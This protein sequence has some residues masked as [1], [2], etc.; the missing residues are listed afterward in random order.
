MQGRRFEQAFGLEVRQDSRR[1]PRAF[2][3]AAVPHLDGESQSFGAGQFVL[4]RECAQGDARDRDVGLRPIGGRY[5][6]VLGIDAL[7]DR[8]TRGR[9]LGAGT[10]L[11]RCLTE[12]RFGGFQPGQGRD[13]PGAI[14]LGGRGTLERILGPFVQIH[15][16]E[17]VLQI[18]D[19]RGVGCGGSDGT[20]EI[21]TVAAAGGSVVLGGQFGLG[22][23]RPVRA[24]VPRCTAR[25]GPRLG[26][27]LARRDAGAAFSD[28]VGGHGAL[29]GQGL[30]GNRVGQVLSKA[31]EARDELLERLPTAPFTIGLNVLRELGALVSDPLQLVAQRI[32]LGTAPL[33]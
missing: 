12:L 31:V 1:S 18:E 11:A 26:D 5:A 29:H 21:R 20:L 8:M 14:G 32:D 27:G 6:V 25:V 15:A 28:P 7:P 2:D 22:R 23:Q 10:E 16:F 33:Q 17:Q 24:R 4:D 19:R 13:V 30:L 3:G 9:R